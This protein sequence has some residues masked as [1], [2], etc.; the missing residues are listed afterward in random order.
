MAVQRADQ[1]LFRSMLP[2]HQPWHF[3]GQWS[4]IKIVCLCVFHQ[5]PAR[6]RCWLGANIQQQ[7]SKGT[8][9]VLQPLTLAQPL[10][11]LGRASA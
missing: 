8:G 9:H 10:Y 11:A 4:R 6:C 2:Q 3:R 7:V 5:S 1:G